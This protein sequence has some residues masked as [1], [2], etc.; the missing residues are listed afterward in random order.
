M[1][2]KGIEFIDKLLKEIDYDLEKFSDSEQCENNNL[3]VGNSPLLH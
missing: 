3:D 2:A 1:T